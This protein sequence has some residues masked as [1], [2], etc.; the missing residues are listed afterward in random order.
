[1]I[2]LGGWFW[3]GMS[4]I[5]VEDSWIYSSDGAPVTLDN[6]GPGQPDKAHASA[7]AEV[8]CLATWPSYQSK[9]SDEGC[10][11]KYKFVCEKPE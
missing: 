2:I 7:S 8:N 9:W 10:E 6:W 5:T 1:M 3:L 11:E 4:D